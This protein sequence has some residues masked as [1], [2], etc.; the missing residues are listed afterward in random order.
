MITLILPRFNNVHVS[1]MDIEEKIKKIEEEIQRTPY[2]KATAHHIGKLKAKISRLK[3]EALQRRSSSGKGKGFHI[4][5]SGDSTVVLIGFPSVGKSTLLNELTNAE[6]KVGEYQFTTLEIVPG[7]MEYRGAQ[8]QIFDIPGI[9]TGASRGKGRGREILSVARSADLIVIV[10]D[11]FNT[12]H[13][14]VILRELRDVGIRPNETP[15]DVTVKRKKLGGVK[16][17]STVELTHLDE[18]IIRSV[19]NEYGIHNAD[20][21]IREDITVDQFIDVME[22]NRAYIPAITVINKIDLVDESYLNH[23]KHEF[24]DALLISAD[25]N[26][27]I[28]ELREEIFNRLGLIRIYMKPQGQKADYSEPL[29]IKEG[30]TV[31]DVCQK[32]HRDFVRKFR[33]ARVWGSSVKFDG[34]KVGIDHVLNDE[35]VLRIIIKK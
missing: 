4:K 25:R 13:M 9:I 1:I 2:N 6:S 24:P 8:I 30:S 23:I 34:Q 16:L 19:L 14:D 11:V 29:I 18:R 27:N 15:P 5:K 28:D 32:L 12:E 7:V 35:D 17:S 26:L 20:V 31:G 22:A 21:L 10:L 33:H 3:E